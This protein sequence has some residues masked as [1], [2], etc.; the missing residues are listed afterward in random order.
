MLPDDANRQPPNSVAVLCCSTEFES[1]T[2]EFTANTAP[3]SDARVPLI[4]VAFKVTDAVVWRPVP[5]VLA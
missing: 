4:R 3:P 5:T 2:T 1:T